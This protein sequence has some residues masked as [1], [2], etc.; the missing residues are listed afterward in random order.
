MDDSYYIRETFFLAEQGVGQ[1]SPNPL[2]GAVVVRDGEIVGRGFHRFNERHHAEVWALEEAGDRAQGATMYTNLEPC[3]HHGRTPP[4]TEAI[5]RAGV[6]RVVSSVRDP[7]PSVCGRGFDQLRAAGIEV[8]SGVCEADGMR[9]NEAFFM[10]QT[11]NRPFVHLK[12]A[13]SLDGRIATRTGASRWITGEAARTAG[14]ELRHRYDAILVGIGTVVADDPRLTDRTGRFRHRPVVRVVLDARLRLPVAS[15]L[16][17][18][19]HEDPVWVFCAASEAD[20]EQ[21]RRRAELERLDV[22]VFETPLVRTQTD[23]RARLDIHAALRA[24]A[25]ETVTGVLVEGGAE[26]AGSFLTAGL[27]DKVTFFIA[28]ILI[29]G[30]AATGAVGGDGFAELRDA[31]RLTD[32]ST[33]HVGGDLVVTGYPAQRTARTPSDIS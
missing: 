15:R 11:E 25:R 2:V 31:M 3:S 7:N 10:Y 30:R 24:L 12:T 4:C 13:A 20:A 26:V 19:A 33:N 17:Q 5:I 21:A 32:V 6:R 8:V 28:P 23:G 9:L 22:K 16:A 27:V 29:G 18:T 14:Q 1:V